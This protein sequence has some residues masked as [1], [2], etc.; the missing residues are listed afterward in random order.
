M[1]WRNIITE[2]NVEK[3]LIYIWQRRKRRKEEEKKKRNIE[4][5]CHPI[6]SVIN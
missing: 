1:F 5:Q 3:T 2:E 6:I 4:K